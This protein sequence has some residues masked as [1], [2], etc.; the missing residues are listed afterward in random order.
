MS[1]VPIPIFQAVSAPRMTS[2][3]REFLVEWKK[4][5]TQYERLVERNDGVNAVLVRDSVD[6]NVL[7]ALVDWFLMWTQRKMS[8]RTC[9]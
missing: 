9:S 2:T 1:E 3:D 6:R 5:R 4:A 7:E 8:L